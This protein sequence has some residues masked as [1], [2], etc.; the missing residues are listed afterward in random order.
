MKIKQ[1]K[2]GYVEYLMIEVTRKCNFT[3]GHCLRGD[4][5]SKDFD[6]NHL[7]MIII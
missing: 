5:Q 6:V 4:A 7:S 3:C 1:I 2:D